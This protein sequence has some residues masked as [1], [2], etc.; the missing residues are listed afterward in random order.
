MCVL[1]VLTK[2]VRCEDGDRIGDQRN[3]GPLNN[4]L[5]RPADETLERLAHPSLRLG[6]VTEI[7]TQHP[8]PC[9]DTE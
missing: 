9:R 5:L 2:I 4:V 8:Q 6:G 7:V 1:L 3:S